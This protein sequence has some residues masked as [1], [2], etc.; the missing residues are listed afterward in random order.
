MKSMINKLKDKVKGANIKAKAL[1]GINAFKS[2]S[3]KKKMAFILAGILLLCFLMKLIGIATKDTSTYNLIETTVERGDIKV[4]LSG[5]SIVEPVEMY[6]VVS[7]VKGD[8]LNDYIEIGQEVKEGDLLYVIDSSDAEKNISKAELSYEKTLLSYNQNV[9]SVENLTITSPASGVI[10]TLNIKEMDNVNNNGK[11]ATIVDYKNLEAKLP[12]LS[13]DAKMLQKGDKVRITVAGSNLE[14]DGNIKKINTGTYISENGALVSD[15]TIEFI[16]PGAIKEDAVVTAISGDI[17]C[18]G[19]GNVKY[20]NLYEIVAKTSG[21]VTGLFYSE[22]DKIEKG[23]IL[24]ILDNDS[25][26]VNAKSSALSLE[27]SK[28]SVEEA[29]ETLDEYNIKSMIDGTVISKTSKA[30]DTID[31][32]DGMKTLAVI[33]DVSK[34]VC[35]LNIDELDISKVQVGQEV[36]VTADAVE[37]KT[38][39]GVVKT[40][41]IMGTTSN[42]TTSY[43]IEIEISEYEDLIPG[44]SVN[45]EIVVEEAKNVLLVPIS[46][47]QRGNMILVKENSSSFKNSKNNVEDKLQNYKD[48]KEGSEEEKNIK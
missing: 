23:D 32:S 34:L 4:T 1:T 26:I 10:T 46:A 25:V 21:E 9:E 20:S 38:F 29:Y 18:N 3:F 24:A 19:S 43:P 30:G 5:S 41:S 13:D 33:A 12:F 6:S 47:V 16:N 31:G 22:G 28:L 8:I 39:K 45:V 11:V 15:V 17:A 27:D 35:S 7:T 2:F 48:N 44:M 37:G 14:L 42:N 36:T 40:K